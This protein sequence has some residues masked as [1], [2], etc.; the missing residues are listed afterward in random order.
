MNRMVE[1]GGVVVDPKDAPVLYG[2]L[3][4]IMTGHSFDREM[5]EE[6]G[7]LAKL[8]LPRDPYRLKIYVAAKLQ[9]YPRVQRLYERL[10]RAGHTITYDWTKLAPPE[11][12]LNAS[13]Y[14]NVAANEVDGVKAC[15]LLLLLAHPHGKG[16][17]VE[18]GVALGLDKPVWII[19]PEEPFHCVFFYHPLS[20]QI[21]EGLLTD[22]FLEEKMGR[23]V[24][25]ELPPPDSD[26]RV[27]PKHL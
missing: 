9:E 3:S 20:G 12:K 21:T 15:D 7:K 8:F 24:R 26:P 16:Q 19:P 1:N 18:M 5:R 6:A 25:G 2:L 23:M 17:Y 10:R 11:I 22:E 27:Y 14:K 13:E 4:M